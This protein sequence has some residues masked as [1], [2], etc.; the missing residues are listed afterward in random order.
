MKRALVLTTVLVG[1]LVA[2]GAVIAHN[3][4][5]VRMTNV[6][7]AIVDFAEG[8][9]TIEQMHAVPGLDGFGS[10][11]DVSPEVLQSN[12]EKS[13]EGC[14]ADGGRHICESRTELAFTAWQ[15]WKDGRGDEAAYNRLE[16]IALDNCATDFTSR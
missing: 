7:Q 16:Q 3:D 15:Q 10:A 13:A 6:C 11:A 4:A 14:R 5:P 12:M 1:A 8:T 9:I 2:G